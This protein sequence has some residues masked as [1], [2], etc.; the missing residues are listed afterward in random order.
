VPS[1]STTRA[2]TRFGS[3]AQGGPSVG[4]LTAG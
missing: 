4:G 1:V 2:L 3:G